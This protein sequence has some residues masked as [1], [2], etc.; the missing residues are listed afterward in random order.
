MPIKVMAFDVHGTLAHFKPDS[1]R[2]IDVQRL[3]ERFGVHISYQAFEAA[4]QAVLFLDGPTRPIEGWPDFLALLFGRLGRPISV[5]VLPD[6]VRLYERGHDLEVYPDAVEALRTAR[7]AGLTTCAFTTLP[8]F[9]LGDAWPQL[10]PHLDHYFDGSE[11]GLAKGDRR[12]YERITDRLG[13]RPDEILAVGDDP[14]CDVELPA[15]AG[16]RSILLDRTDC[17]GERRVG[18]IAR[19]RSLA[20]LGQVCSGSD[21]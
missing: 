8:R 4:R 15:E 18:R 9:M 5:D 11:I 12:F 19:I 3:L 17:R 13:V 16:W 1:V 14:I 21:S 2:P 20:E 6:V 7:A 10:E